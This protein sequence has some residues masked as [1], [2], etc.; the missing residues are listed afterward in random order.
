[1]K[2]TTEER[3]EILRK[4]LRDTENELL[5]IRQ[6]RPLVDIGGGWSQ[7]ISFE[8]MSEFAT[9]WMEQEGIHTKEDLEA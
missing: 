3:L 1:M 6:L 8:Q 4:R 7:C 5:R 9:L 2:Y